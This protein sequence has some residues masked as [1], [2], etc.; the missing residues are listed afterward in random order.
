MTTHK[1]TFEDI[2][3][4]ELMVTAT[5]QI[6]VV[7]YVGGFFRVVFADGRK[8]WFTF[9]DLSINNSVFF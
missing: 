5:G 8:K 4:G 1:K 3:V 7:D 9:T 6:G 2:V